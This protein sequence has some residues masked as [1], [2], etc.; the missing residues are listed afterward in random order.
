MIHGAT[1]RSAPLAEALSS[2]LK[3]NPGKNY[4]L[5]L[6]RSIRR[7]RGTRRECLLR[8]DLVSTLAVA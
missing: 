2:E 8:F 3:A 4:D 5:V 1:A 6:I 7:F